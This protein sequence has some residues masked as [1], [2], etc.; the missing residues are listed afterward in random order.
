MAIGTAVPF[1]LV[2]T[3][4]YRERGSIVFGVFRRFPAWVQRMAILAAGREIK[5]FVVRVGS[6]RVIGLMARI[7]LRRN[8]RIAAR[9]MTTGTVVDGMSSFE[10]EK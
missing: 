1:A 9:S 3:R 5:C 7:A 8:F 10:R 4:I 2:G 6:C